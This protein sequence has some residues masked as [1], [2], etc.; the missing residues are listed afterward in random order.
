MGLA[1]KR[2]RVESDLT[3]SIPA[4]SAVLD[5][6]RRLLAKHPV[7]DWVAIDM[8][9]EG[10]TPDSERLIAAA[11]TVQASLSKT[12]QFRSVGNREWADGF[13]ALHESLVDRLPTLF[14]SDEL[15]RELPSRIT[16]AAIRTRLSATLEQ[17]NA[18]DGMGQ[19]HDIAV[20]PLGL[21]DLVYSRLAGVLPKTSAH[22]EQGHLISEDGK[23]LL[24]TAVPHHTLG[25]PESSRRIANAIDAAQA[26]LEHA[27]TLQR[28]VPIRLTASGAYRAAMDNEAIVKQDTNRAVWLVTVAVSLLL[29]ACFSRPVLGLLTLLPATAGVAVALLI[30]SFVRPSMSAL[31]LGF[32]AALISITVDQ[33][34]VYIAYL[35]RVR[36]ATGKKAAEQTFSAVSLATLTTVGAFFALKFSG[37]SLLEEL[38]LFA[39]LG[40]ACSFIF[41]H[42][43]FPWVFRAAPPVHRRPWLPIDDALRWLATGRAWPRIAFAVLTSVV[44]GYFARPHFEVD[45][46]R[47]NTV[48]A[49]TKAADATVRGVW[50]DLMNR[51]YVLVEAKDVA[52][53]Q[54][55]S[56]A[57][58]TFLSRERAL[59]TTSTS[60]SPSQL[61]PGRTLAEQHVADWRSFWNQK[62]REETRKRLSTV[63][64]ELGFAN[65]A[66]DPFFESIDAPKVAPTPIPQTAYALLGIA[67][68]RDGVGWVWLG[69]IERGA[70]YD[71][72]A[73]TARARAIGVSI[74]DGG[75]FARGL[76]DF[77]GTAFKRML[78]IVSPFV[79]L[80]VGLSFH[81]LR[82]IALVLF[83]VLWSLIA[84]L[85]SFGLMH[86]A[87]DIPGLM[88]AVV[89][90]GM[91]TNFSVYLVH[92]H[93]RYPD[94]THPVHDS[95]RI[96][97]LL[98][99]GATVLGMAVLAA[100]AH[101]AA[102]GA[103]V[104]GLLGIGFSLFGSLVLLPPM[105]K[106]VAPID[107]PWA[108]QRGWPAERLFLSRFRY[109][110][111]KPLWRARQ[112]LRRDRARLDALAK[113]LAG[114][115]RV[116]VLG[117]EYAIEAAWLL[118]SDSARR[119]VVVEPDDD[120]RALTSG[121]IADRGD[122][123]GSDFAPELASSCDAMLV[124]LPS[125]GA[126]SAS[127]GTEARVAQPELSTAVGHLPQQARVVVIGDLTTSAVEP[128]LFDN[129]FTRATSGMGDAVAVF[130]R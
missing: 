18:L 112:C 16:E 83:P 76:N 102:R 80:A 30:Y 26:E 110:E 99:G 79:L 130:A 4:G 85:G 119:V 67:P 101:A 31:A 9:S 64:T 70:H 100:S 42:T 23:H 125:T 74:F 40:S 126:G 22:I 6:G 122:V 27:A 115:Q 77:L 36:G 39:A 59:G 49:A 129:G 53:L 71:A 34:I 78:L 54:Q 33:G 13:A 11:E 44:L 35:D 91:G 117:G 29:L 98:D 21:R 114:A 72:V 56:D 86:R 58:A 75:Q 61:W 121:V 46:N 20:D 28:A 111:P 10:G 118:A 113:A 24:L 84:T 87:I 57:L 103:G 15:E 81:H 51:S 62:R 73:F 123:A 124:V 60:F 120:R 52:A 7:I 37:Y 12:G 106:L 38:G 104:A 45:L 108:M 19:A 95:V 25:D 41:V 14:S 69:A 68:S 97:T 107:A 96:A 32:G 17:L 92:A 93:Q 109:L 63:A 127:A 66:F 3:A 82:L 43:V 128:C 88:I 116:L 94:P 50:G 48:S 90:L 65:D 89:V 55:R 5:S 1:L 2:I 8:S 47:L 105:L